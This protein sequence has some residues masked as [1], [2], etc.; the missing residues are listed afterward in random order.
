MNVRS[1]CTLS[2]AAAGAFL[3]I[4]AGQAITITADANFSDADFAALFNSG[5]FDELFVA[6]SRI[7]NNNANNGDQ[8]IQLLTPPPNASAVD[9]EQFAWTSGEAVAF[10]L[11]YD[12]TE[13]IYTVGGRVVS[14]TAFS[15]SANEIFLRTRATDSASL[16]L[17]NLT[18][19]GEAIAEELFS[20][21]L[22]TSN[23][24]DV[25]YLR[26]QDITSPFVFS[27]LSTLTWSEDTNRLRGS[28]LA[29]QIKVGT[30]T[31]N[32]PGE[33]ESTPEPASLVGLLGVAAVG[34]AGRKL[35]R[36]RRS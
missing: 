28:H 15:G 3:P 2:L 9:R 19:N 1:L 10:S 36:G 20:S 30:G 17:S 22:G 18:F 34:L 29:Y 13:A 32:A 21:T 7:G 33:V 5:E 16:L 23:S 31:F 14:T 25:D 12:G 8:E 24:S 27:G 26:I 6:E 35:G 4:A 11:E